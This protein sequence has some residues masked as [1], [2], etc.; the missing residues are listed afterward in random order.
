ML[1]AAILSLAPW[2]SRK[3]SAARVVEQP[4]CGCRAQVNRGHS[5]T[6]QILCDVVEVYE[7]QKTLVFGETNEILNHA[8]IPG[9]E[10]QK[11]TTLR[12]SAITDLATTIVK[13]D[14]LAA[15]ITR[16][17]SGPSEYL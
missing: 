8:C 11:S 17:P 6:Q 15:G 16:P 5:R 12:Y 10:I 3:V 4:V 13:F 2:T 7:L 9:T 14:V 1:T